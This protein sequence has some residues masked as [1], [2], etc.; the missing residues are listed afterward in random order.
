MLTKIDRELI[1]LKKR[2]YRLITPCCSSSNRDGKFINYKGFPEVFGYCYS[3]GIATTPPALYNNEKG[4][5]FI[6]NEIVKNW[7]PYNA[8]FPIPITIANKERKKQQFV[9]ESKIWDAYIIRPENNLIHYL[10]SKYSEEDINRALELYCLGS[11]KNGGTVFWQIDKANRVLKNKIC[12]YD[13]EG[14]RRNKFNVEYKN[15]DC[16]YSGLFGAHLLLQVAKID[17]QVALVESEKT[18]I[19]GEILMP[20]FTWIA[21]GGINGLTDSKMECLK[22]RNIILIPDMS[23]KALL[24][25]RAKITDLKKICAEAKLWDMTEGKTDLQLKEEGIYNND[26]EDYFRKII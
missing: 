6:W 8:T 17:Q 9:P 13:I 14:K 11:T 23:E 21:Y 5:T 1:F 22:G 7:Q 3:C 20:Q 10:R 16:F 4:E 24:I 12:F 25:G 2:N 19:V 15:E 26:L 18:A